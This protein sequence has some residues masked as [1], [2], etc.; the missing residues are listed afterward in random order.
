[1]RAATHIAPRLYWLYTPRHASTSTPM[2]RHSSCASLCYECYE[3]ASSGA[4]QKT[5]S[6]TGVQ[7]LA[8]QSTGTAGAS[9]GS[10]VL[11]MPLWAQRKTCS[12]RALLATRMRYACM[13]YVYVR[14]L[15]TYACL[16]RRMRA[17]LCEAQDMPLKIARELCRM[18]A[19]LGAYASTRALKAVVAPARRLCG[20]KK[21]DTVAPERR[22]RA[23]HRRALCCS[24]T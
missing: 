11:R 9:L 14:V 5:S 7:A 12:D 6:S 20:K 10:R 19:C 22:C 16:F 15:R 8:L 17:F 24:G 18:S 1:M 3:C 13:R 2:H 4:C 21:K 23:L